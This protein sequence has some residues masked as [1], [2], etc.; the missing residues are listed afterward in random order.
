MKVMIWMC[1]LRG[2]IAYALCINMPTKNSAIETT[3]LFIAVTTTL[4]FGILTAPMA[5]ALGLTSDS[6]GN[7]IIPVIGRR[8]QVEVAGERVFTRS[9]LHRVFKWFDKVYLKP[10]FGGRED[11]DIREPLN[12]GDSSSD[13]S[14][15]E[16]RRDDGLEALSDDDESFKYPDVTLFE[17]PS[18]VQSRA[19]QQELLE[20][21]GPPL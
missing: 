2:P 20:G 18:P 12:G 14:S 17:I 16:G 7:G 8:G 6:V 15:S 21:K 3:T 11:G 5:K 4:V 10:V 13:D 9:T 19:A 1:G